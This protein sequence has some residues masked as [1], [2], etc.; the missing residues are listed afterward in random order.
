M[1]GGVSGS[2]THGDLLAGCPT[3]RRVGLTDG[4]GVDVGAMTVAPGSVR[5]ELD[6]LAGTGTEVVFKMP[7][8]VDLE[9]LMDPAAVPDAVAMGRRQ[10]AADADELRSFLA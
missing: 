10:A 9:T 2:G 1:D 7:E 3:R 8:R 4:A 6:A 5:R